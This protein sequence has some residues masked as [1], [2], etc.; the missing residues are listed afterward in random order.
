MTTSIGRRWKCSDAC[1]RAVL[2]ARKLAH[3]PRNF[4]KTHFLFLLDS[5]LAR[6]PASVPF[7]SLYIYRSGLLGPT[8]QPSGRRS[9]WPWRR[10]PPLSIPNREVKPVSADGTATPGGRVGR[11]LPRGPSL[12]SG[13]PFLLYGVTVKKNS[14]RIELGNFYIL[15]GCG[16]DS[17]KPGAGLHRPSGEGS[18]PPLEKYPNDGQP[19]CLR[20]W[21]K[22]SGI[23]PFSGLHRQRFRAYWSYNPLQRP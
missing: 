11:R 7:M 2:I 10:G 15:T 14:Q 8:G 13:G 23:V 12:K 4:L 5:F 21:P 22:Q 19:V 17:F 3:S 1:S 20:K 16:L 6:C 9:R 18:I